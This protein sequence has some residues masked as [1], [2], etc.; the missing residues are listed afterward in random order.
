MHQ[1]EGELFREVVDYGARAC[2]LAVQSLPSDAP[3]DAAARAL[4]WKRV[5]LD[6]LIIALGKEVGSP[7]GQ[8]QKEAAA[9]ALAA[10]RAKW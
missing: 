9:A 3:M 4:G 8:H 10:L 6:A 1:V 2:K 7:W 5:K